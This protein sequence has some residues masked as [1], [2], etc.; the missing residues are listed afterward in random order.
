MTGVMDYSLHSTCLE[1][2]QTAS[3]WG[4]DEYE[5]KLFEQAS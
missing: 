2:L 5:Y 3:Y 1:S 4:R